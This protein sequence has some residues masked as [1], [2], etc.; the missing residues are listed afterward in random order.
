MLSG[1]VF[2]YGIP[3]IVIII[4]DDPG[5]LLTVRSLVFPFID[6]H[7]YSDIIGNCLYCCTGAVLT[8]EGRKAHCWYS[9]DDV[10]TA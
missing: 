3:F 5:I 6:I 8:D 7:P 2:N 1:I 10:V 4:I 9:I